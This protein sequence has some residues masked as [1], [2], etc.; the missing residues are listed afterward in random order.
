MFVGSPA[1]AEGTMRE[2]F[3]ESRREFLRGVGAAGVTLIVRNICPPAHSAAADR[4][5]WTGAPGKARYRID[6]VAKVI[7]E[8]IYARDFRARDMEGWPAPERAALVVRATCVDRRFRGLDLAPLAKAG[9]APRKVVLAQD[10][11]ADEIMPSGF[12]Q[13]PAG[14]PHGILVANDELPV[15][16]G[17]P[18]AILIFDDYRTWQRAGKVLRFNAAIARYGANE[19][20][21]EPAR[22]PYSPATYL[23]L[24][25]DGEGERFSQAKNGRGNPY[26]ADPT[27][28]G[29]E[30]RKWRDKI[31]QNMAQP[32]LRVFEG[33]YA[34]QALD[35]VFLEPEAGLAW[36]DR[37]APS[38]TLHL[39][40]GTQSGSGDLQD[41]L[42]LL[43][44]RGIDTV[45]L[46]ACYPG[47]GFGGRDESPFPTLLSIAAF[48]ADGPVRLA[49]SRFE[50]FQAGLKQLAAGVTHRIAVDAQG[51][52]RAIAS[53]LTL[54][55][56]GNNNYSQWVAQL[57]G[58]S[59]AGGYH[60]GQAAIGA[61]AAPTPGIVAGS[62][63]GFGGPQA[64]FAIEGLVEEIAETMAIDPIELRRRNVLRSGDATITGAIPA[65]AMRLV[66]ICD[67]AAGRA[68]WKHRERDRQAK[69]RDGKLYGVGFALANQPFGTGADGVMAEVSMSRGGEIAVRTHC[70]DMGNGSATSLA[71]CVGAEL[72]RNA[73]AIQMG[74][75]T[76]L[77]DALGLDTTPT[78]A[79]NNWANPRWTAVLNG[80]SSACL[81]AFHHAHVVRQAA[82]VL[83][84]TGVL[85]AARSL[86]GA[87]GFGHQGFAAGIP[88][89]PRWQ[90]GRLIAPGRRP[91]DIA[92]LAAEMHRKN[93]VNGVAAHAVFFGRW[94]RADY[95]VDGHMLHLASDGLSTRLAN[96]TGWRRHDRRNVV[97]PPENAFLLGRNLFAP[98]G[99][100]VAVE[101]D[102]GSCRVSVVEAE[103]FLD[104]GRVISPDIVAG[105]A[106]GGLAMGIGYALMENAPGGE[107][108]PGNGQWNLHLYKVPRARD[109]PLGSMKLTLLGENDATSRGIGEAVLCPV[110]AAI[111][112]AV[113]HASGRRPRSLPI[114]PA[115][116]REVLA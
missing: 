71:I 100:L 76:Y 99:A 32:A 19:S 30:A 26:A 89:P 17:Q 111:A 93:L 35:P 61:M 60:I 44:P 79:A 114:T 42:A 27:P 63:R 40:L 67:R 109:V 28:A 45:V 92:E 83:Y 34:T 11:A 75:T 8:K 49:C 41:A 4:P 96:D 113:A 33:T 107:E 82:S 2:H 116:V 14:S 58:V 110:P 16:F 94:V 74:D 90:D 88:P 105:Q 102:R 54:T 15:Y 68:L 20:R 13:P 104:A 70:I 23:T 43:G 37:T 57:A 52:F 84:R 72:G 12:Q 5:A 1:E 25:R 46:N 47:G 38:P 103:T 53:K 64:V 3:R 106:D 18:L 21:P 95:D 10:L 29:L 39:V 66:E 97:P 55:A 31:N 50:Q 77:V 85:P 112:N 24:Y 9:V 36:L 98:S 6:G 115:W 65:Q 78:R 81:T 62:M 48:Y 22:A 59:A 7:G 51:R 86:W 87:D 69:S 91:L 101:I 108:G 73:S 80:S 56:G